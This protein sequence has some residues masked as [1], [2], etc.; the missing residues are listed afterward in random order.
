MKLVIVDDE[1]IERKAMRKFIEQSMTG[2][3][4][5]GE[6]ANGR[7]AVELAAEL[8]PD[9][10]LMDIKMPGMDGL[11]AIRQI[12]KINPFIRFI[13]VSAYDSDDYAKEA[14]K[15]GVKEF[16]L[17]PGKKE[18]TISA[19]F[20]V[21]KEIEG[22]PS[23]SAGREDLMK[24]ELAERMIRKQATAVE[25]RRFLEH[26]PDAKGGFSLVI[27]GCT[28]TE[29][30]PV[31]DRHSPVPYVFAQ[32]KNDH[33]VILFL[34][35][36]AEESVVRNDALRLARMITFSLKGSRAGVGY[37]VSSIE[38]FWKSYREAEAAWA[39]I[40]ADDSVAYQFYHE[41]KAK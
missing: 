4:V 14:W 6:A 40:S 20:R 25:Y 28:G 2:F 27:S 12:R 7:M 11:E 34:A 32:E 5:A 29:L 8:K 23:G 13:M 21:K 18:D 26:F 9:L 15:E 41:E 10:M 1:M 38:N 30:H 19:L 16:I 3:E 39:S 36:E 33:M 24:R 35:E 31:L 22:N 17:K 37:P